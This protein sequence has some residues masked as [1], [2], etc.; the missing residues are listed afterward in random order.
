MQRYIKDTVIKKGWFNPKNDNSNLAR[1]IWSKND[2]KNYYSSLK[3][4]QYYNHINGSFNLTSKEKLHEA[5]SVT[6]STFYPATYNI[7]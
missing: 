1:L 2:N 7:P 3:Q 4:G 6:G 5:L